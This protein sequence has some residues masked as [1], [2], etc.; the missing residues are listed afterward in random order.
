MAAGSRVVVRVMMLPLPR[1]L[2]L[3]AAEAAEANAGV[4]EADAWVA[5]AD[6]GVAEAPEA[7]AGHESAKVAGS[8]EP[9]GLGGGTWL[10]MSRCRGAHPP[11]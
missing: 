1:T 5:E 7:G 3:V 6:A 10:S 9:A 8:W 4:A 2:R 11:F